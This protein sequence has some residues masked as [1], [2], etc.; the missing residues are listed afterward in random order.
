MILETIFTWVGGLFLILLLIGLIISVIW[1]MIN[2]ALWKTWKV[3]FKA[4]YYHLVSEVLSK[5]NSNIKECKLHEGMSWYM[6]FR[7][8]RYDWK[9]IKIE[10][11]KED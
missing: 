10:D 9:L 7:G 8:K 11:I 5:D 3:T 1:W 6:R 4:I 2:K